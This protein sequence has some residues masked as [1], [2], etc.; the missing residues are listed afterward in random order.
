MRASNIITVNQLN[1]LLHNK[2]P[3]YNCIFLLLNNLLSNFSHIESPQCQIFYLGEH[4]NVVVPGDLCKRHLH[5]FSVSRNCKFS[6][7]SLQNWHFQQLCKWYL[8]KWEICIT[9]CQARCDK[10]FF[11]LFSKNTWNFQK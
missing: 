1:G 8:H 2:S 4:R 7:S 5:K 9:R 6:K 3:P 10:K 11:A